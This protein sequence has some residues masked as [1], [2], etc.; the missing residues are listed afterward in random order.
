MTTITLDTQTFRQIATDSNHA[1]YQLLN[2]ASIVGNAV[3]V[4]KDKAI[5]QVN[6]I[7]M[8]SLS[9]FLS[10]VALSGEIKNYPCWIEIPTANYEDEIPGYLPDFTQVE[11]DQQNQQPISRR[12]KWSE[13]NGYGVTHL[14]YDNKKYIP[15]NHLSSA[16]IKELSDNLYIILDTIAYKNLLDQ[17]T[18]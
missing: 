16:N 9:T 6:E 14:E 12:A 2:Y 5:L 18:I 4:E 15:I 13:I 8:F 7:D 17:I 3:K 10:V 1:L 11:I